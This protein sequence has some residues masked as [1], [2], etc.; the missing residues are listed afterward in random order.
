MDHDG[1]KQGFAVDPVNK[2]NQLLSIPV[3]ASGGAGRME[4][5]LE[6]FV[7]GHANAGLA[8]SVFHFG[9]IGIPDLKTFLKKNLVPIR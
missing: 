9:E 6:I 1:T 2:L 5:F 3:F 8:A 7:S 4:H